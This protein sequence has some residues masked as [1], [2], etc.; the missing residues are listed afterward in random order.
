[1][2]CDVFNKKQALKLLKGKHIW[3][4]GSSNM[5]AIYKDLLWLITHGNI[6]PVQSFQ[7]REINFRCQMFKNMQDIFTTIASVQSSIFFISFLSFKMS[8]DYNASVHK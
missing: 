7:V 6:A 5:R 1:M 3:F 8:K 2:F 4:I